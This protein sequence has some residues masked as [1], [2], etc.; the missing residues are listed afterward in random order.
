MIGNIRTMIRRTL[1][2]ARRA[3]Q[4]LLR[5]PPTRRY[6]SSP[7]EPPP[8]SSST[9][10]PQSRIS[11]LNARL[12]RFLH[13][14]TSALSSAP[15]THITAFLLLHEITAI[16]PLLGLAATFH[17]THW[18]P[19]WFAEGAWVLKGVERFGLYF[20]RKGWIREE[21]RGEAEREIGEHVVE[22]ERGG[23]GRMGRWR[24]MTERWR[25]RRDRA[26]DVGE[27]GVRLVVEFATAY[28]IVK[29]LLP[30]RVVL[31]VWATPWFAGW[32][33][34]PVKRWLGMG[35]VDEEGNILPK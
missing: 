5:K 33:V 15:L 7:P 2:R 18:L 31:S 19:S 27:G 9:S 4:S 3:P 22:S 1:L 8:P 35:R 16:V 17:Y 12:P 26:W 30:V 32:A 34:V 29:A 21:E 13:K 10:S 14:Y 20:K 11:R 6:A 23:E 25:R 24:G 28:A